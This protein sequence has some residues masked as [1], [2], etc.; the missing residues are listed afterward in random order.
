MSP[1][2]KIAATSDGMKDLEAQREGKATATRMLAVN[3]FH[4][5]H[6]TLET[7][8]REV[9]NISSCPVNDSPLTD[10]A[11][12]LQ[13]HALHA[14]TN[15]EV[16]LFA[17]RLQSDQFMR[18]FIINTSDLAAD[19]FQMSLGESTSEIAVRMEAFCLSGVKG[20]RY[21]LLHKHTLIETQVSCKPTSSS[22]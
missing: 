8:E 19:F 12:F 6:R 11:A 21:A 18:P 17:T 22:C 9:R 10:F 2:E 1:D 13:I 14:R 3:S 20:V 16:V 4:D 7:L 5:A 15:I